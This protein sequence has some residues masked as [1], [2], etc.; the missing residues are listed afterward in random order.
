M[1]SRDIFKIIK[2]LEDCFSN[3]D[4]TLIE[5][6]FKDNG[7]Q[8]E[9]TFELLM[10][11]ST[12]TIA[13]QQNNKEKQ[14]SI[15]SGSNQKRIEEEI[16]NSRSKNS[17]PIESKHIGNNSTPVRETKPAEIKDNNVN[18]IEQK[19]KANKEKI[20][21]VSNDNVDSDKKKSLGNKMKSK[22]F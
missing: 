18:S 4:P 20:I 8:T 13:E 3:L 19:E 21:G 14:I 12:S 11:I 1:D 22:L 5:E 7:Y 16:K 10:I 6:I 9:K 15:T 2:E 17:N